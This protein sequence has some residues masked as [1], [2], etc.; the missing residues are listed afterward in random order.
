MAADRHQSDVRRLEKHA[1]ANR[2]SAVVD[3]HLRD[4]DMTR[5]Q[6]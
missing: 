3:Q 6:G 5:S 4:Q 2:S 1:W